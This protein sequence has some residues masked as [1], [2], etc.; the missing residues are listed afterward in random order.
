MMNHWIL[1]KIRAKKRLAYRSDTTHL[2]WDASTPED[3]KAA[4]DIALKRDY[5]LLIGDNGR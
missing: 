2:L 3:R 5:K 1:A 4:D